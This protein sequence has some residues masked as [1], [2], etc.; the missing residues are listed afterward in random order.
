MKSTFTTLSLFLAV[1]IPSF[2]QDN[3]ALF[4]VLASKGSNKYLSLNTSDETPLVIGKKLT[5]GDKIVI[6]E[7]GY[8]GLA[9]KS[10][11]TIEIKKPGTYE[12]NQLVPQVNAQN[13]GLSKKY[14]DF[15]V[16]EMT[17]SAEDMSKNRHK[18]MA[19]TGSVERG[20]YSIH[21]MVPQGKTTYVIAQPVKIKWCAAADAKSYAVRV[22]NM[23]DE[24]LYVMETS[25]TSAMLDM[26]KIHNKEEDL[27][28]IVRISS[29]LKGK[30]LHAPDF[31][32]RY[33][34]GEKGKVLQKKLNE[35][36]AELGEETALQ[37]LLLASFYEENNL[38]LN[39]MEQYEA[40]IQLQPE[41]DDFKFIY[42]Q[43]LIRA[44]MGVESVK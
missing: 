39:A 36:T 1:V 14:I 43:F 25:D 29:K 22:D 38:L 27:Q 17:A 18:Y 40:A 7:N 2:S 4:K 23:F 19:V 3:D 13:A 5:K 12:V 11:K 15:V 9:Y 28:C 10:G 24:Q 41:V 6:D 8:A 21:M 30:E 37:K 42:N 33:L 35:L 31:S 44:G 34:G 16:G 26:G 20:N 32:L